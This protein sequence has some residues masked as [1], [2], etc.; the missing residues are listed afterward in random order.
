MIS[1]GRVTIP[2]VTRR[3]LRVE[4]GDVVEV[5][6]TKHMR[7]DRSTGFYIEVDSSPCPDC[8]AQGDAVVSHAVDVDDGTDNHRIEGLDNLFGEEDPKRKR[9]EG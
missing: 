6:V 4:D 2:V 7:L 9:R 3:L 1:G 8:G 5:E